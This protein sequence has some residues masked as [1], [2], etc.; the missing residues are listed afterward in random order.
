MLRATI[1]GADSIRWRGIGPG[2]R[3]DQ[4]RPAGFRAAERAARERL[5]AEGMLD[6][7]PTLDRPRWAPRHASPTRSPRPPR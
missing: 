4:D 6:T 1:P 7:V 3:F 2:G 5:E